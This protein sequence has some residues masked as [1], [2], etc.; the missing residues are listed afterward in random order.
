[1]RGRPLILVSN[2]DGVGAAG[3]AAV[4][5]VL[6]GAGDVWIVAPDGERSS[7]GH[8]MTLSG[9]VFC[10][11]AGPRTF[12]V[13][14]MP[15]DAVFIAIADLLPRRPDLVVSG[16]NHGPNLGKDVFY[17]G[18]VAAAREAA[19]RGIP[20]MAVSLVR[21][22]DFSHAAAI[23]GRLSAMMLSAGCP[24]PRNRTAGGPFL[25]VNVPQGRPRGASWTRLG[26][27]EYGEHVIR[28]RSPRGRAYYWINGGPQG[29]PSARLTDIWAVRRGRVSVTPLTLDETDEQS[30]G[31]L[32]GGA[33]DAIVED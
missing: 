6:A 4:S 12:E 20:A 19:F 15:G 11:R 17:S 33:L 23:A 8:A 13:S 21:G 28:R 14:G 5:S 29:V 27:R 18:T 26:R 10:R 30:I 32:P 16:I 2:D 24:F 7:C 25:N 9:P 1:M 22:S 31:A 3:I